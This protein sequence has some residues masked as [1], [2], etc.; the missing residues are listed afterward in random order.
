[1]MEDRILNEKESLALISQMILNTKKNFRRNAGV[2]A[3]VW[4]YATVLTSILVYVGWTVTNEQW[5][6][7]GWFL[8]PVLGVIGSLL[9]GKRKQPVLTKTILDRVVKYIWMVLGVVCWG[10]S[11]AAFIFN[12]PILF[13]VSILMSAA[14]TLTGCV[15]DYKVYIYFGIAGILLSFLCLAVHGPEQILIFAGIFVIMMII[16]SHLLNAEMKKYDN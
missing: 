9:W 3:L 1:M 2:P 14:I 13:F 7:Y 4:G 8:I 10:V 5:V 15:A 11:V 6:M 16:P 12:F